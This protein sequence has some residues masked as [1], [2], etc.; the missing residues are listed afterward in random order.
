MD[1]DGIMVVAIIQIV[2]VAIILVAQVALLTKADIIKTQIAIID[3]E[4]IK[5]EENIEI[6]KDLRLRYWI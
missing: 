1:K 3:M 5:Q 4:F 6:N 2:M